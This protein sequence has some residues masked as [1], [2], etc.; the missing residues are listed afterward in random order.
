MPTDTSDRSRGVALALAAVL[1]PFGA[2]RFY[3]GKIRSGVLMA[4]TLGGGGLWWV[5]DL[6][7][8]GAGEFRDAEGRLVTRWEP[9]A[10][11]ELRELPEQVL[12]ELDSLRREVAEL[13]ER[14]DFTER[15]L[16]NPEPRQAASDV[17]R[18]RRP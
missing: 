15:L 8:L 14:V 5:Y 6:I 17:T 13:H 9:G 16:A 12:E 1:G 3:T 18:F 10:A 7:V 2:H 11:P 4:L